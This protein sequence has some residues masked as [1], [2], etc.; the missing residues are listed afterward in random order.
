MPNKPQITLMDTTL[1]DGEQTQ[2]VSFAPS[3]KVSL[4]QALLGR[5]K[6]DRIEVASAGVS[7]GEQEAVR[8][9][10]AWAKDKGYLERVEVLGFVDHNRSIDWIVGAGGKVINLLT[11]GSENHCRKQLRQTPEQHIENI[12]KTIDYAEQQGVNVNVYLEDWSNGYR[13][14]PEYVYH[15]VESLK[16]RKIGHFMLPD[17]LGVMSPDEVTAAIG[18]MVTRFPALS[19][20]FH[21]HNDYGLATA[22][23]MAAVD[24]GIHSIHCTV[25][26]LGERAGNASL[27]EVAVVLRDKMGIDLNI[28]EEHIVDISQMVESFSGKF[29]ACNAPI[30]GSDVFT[31]TAGIHADGD[32]KANLYVTHLTPE[33]FARK[34]TYALGKLAGKA[35]LEQNLD[36]MGIS[37]SDEDQKKVLAKVIQ[38]GDSKQIITPEDLPFI[39]ADV[40]GSNDAARVMLIDCATFSPLSGKSSVEL[41]VSV[42]GK[43]LSEKGEGNGAYDAFARALD[44][45]LIDYP[46]LTRPKLIDYQVH[47]PKGGKT[48]ALTEASITWELATGR[49]MTTRGVHSNQVVAAM[50]ATLKAINSNAGELVQ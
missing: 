49:K 9:I 42:D 40:L 4:A 1:R 6:V 11:K 46:E 24:A 12:H 16:D 5:L 19:F 28:A 21:P 30:L 48:N 26:C 34:R 18:D 43:T 8:K 23:V 13:D 41:T 17:T 35:S 47:I 33:R 32:K 29:V 31:Q 22:N 7:A 10:N 25:N 14:A 15:L 2:G 20:D 39:I 36:E 3:E 50:Y 45:I 37:L 27:A 44:E 38:L